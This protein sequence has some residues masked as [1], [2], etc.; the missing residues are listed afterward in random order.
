MHITKKDIKKY[1]LFSLIFVWLIIFFHLW[2]LYLQQSNKEKPIKWWILLE[3][4]VWEKINPLPYLWNWYYSRYVQSL[5]YRWCLNNDWTPDLCNVKT[6]D[7]KT[8]F[9]TLTWNNYWTSWRK[10]TLDDVYFTYND[11][12]KNNS[13]NLTYPIVNDLKSVVKDWNTI[14][15]VF[16]QASINNDSFFQNYILP[17]YLLKDADKNFYISEYSQKHINSTCVSL[18][19]KSNFKTNLILDYSKCPNYYINKYQFDLFKNEKQLAKYWTGKTNIDIYNWYTNINKDKYSKHLINLKI[20][21][22][23]FWNTKK[24]KNE[25]VKDYLSQSILAYLKK[26]L[27]LQERI[28][29]VWY[30][31]FVLQKTNITNTWFKTILWKYSLDKQKAEFRKKIFNI[32]N[33]VYLYKQWKN[34]VAY[35]DK[36]DKYLVLKWT[37][38]T[39]W[40]DKIWVSYKTWNEYILKEYNCWKDIKY[41][42]S[43]KFWN[44]QKWINTYKI[45]WYKNSQKKLLDTITLY[46][47]S[48]VYPKFKITY[49]NFT[50]LYLNKGLI[51]NI[52]DA[53]YNILMKI[54]PWQIIVKKV[55]T[56]EYNDILLSWNYDLAISSV[57]FRWKDISYIFKTDKATNNPSL[58]K[59]ANFASLINQDFL[60]PL[61]LKKKIFPELNKIYQAIIPVVFIWNEKINLY[62]NK[63]YN[64]PNLDYSIFKNRKEMLKSIVLTKIK[65]TT[66]KGVSFHWFIKFLLGL[67]K[68]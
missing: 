50:L 12:I 20:R 30:G 21:Y 8:Y 51:A 33:S 7:H 49:P 24:Q 64:V 54:Y 37:L 31:L 35:V 18:D 59:N 62:V 1:I 2:Y 16:N 63:K 43:E 10:I 11:I 6:S 27:T 44:I 41:V 25:E 57:S 23:M 29:F 9:V 53:V 32:K 47:K 3:W 39:W 45:Y 48:V 66:L 17:E 61:D 60:A 56:Q 38:L 46:Y 5:L 15:V 28:N 58:F 26:D 68:N 55:W 14:K 19:L 67:V 65:Q 36:I 34:N 4:V 13:L 42:M 52:W 40:Y 22:A